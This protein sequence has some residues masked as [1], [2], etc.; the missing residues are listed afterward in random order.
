MADKKKKGIWTKYEVKGD[1]LERKNQWSPKL[2][3]GYFMAEHSNRRTCGQTQY[4][5]F[6]KKE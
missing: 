4:T 6:K 3:P 1:K 5:E 2:G